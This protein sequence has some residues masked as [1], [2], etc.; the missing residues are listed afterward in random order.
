M[1]GHS[2][3]ANIQ[4]RKGRQDEKRGKIWTKLIKEIT[5]AAKL[6]GGDIATNPRLRLAIDKA[7]DSNMPNDNVQRA[8]QRGTGSLEGVNYEEIRYEGYGINGAAVIVDCMTDNRTRTVAEV[9]HAFTKHGGNMGTEGSVAFLF[10]HCGQMLFA[11]GVNED[12]LM[13]LALDAGAEDVITHEDGSIEVLTPVPDF[14]KVQDAI[15]KAGLKAELAT[16]AMRPETEIALEGEQAESMQKLL[17]VL[18]N[19]DDVQEVFTN[20]A[21]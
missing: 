16:I 13:E 8:I 3:W 12:Q 7:K 1:A 10:K 9:R 14:S 21:F 4:H 19:L 17:D 18:E 11:P 2:K 15:A 20:A 5:V 6:G